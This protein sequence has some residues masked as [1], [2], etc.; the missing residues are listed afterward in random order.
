[1]FFEYVQLFLYLI[2]VIPWFRL[3]TIVFRILLLQFITV[4]IYNV[5]VFI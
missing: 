2:I 1:M 3:L 5:I 4:N